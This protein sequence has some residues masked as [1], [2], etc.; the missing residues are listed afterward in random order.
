MT[1]AEWINCDEPGPMLALLKGKISDR[2]AYLFA[3]A[4][5]QLFARLLPDSKQRRGVQLLE[6]I[7]EGTAT[8]QFVSHVAAEVFRAT[9]YS[10]EI[11][12]VNRPDDPYMIARMLHGAIARST[13]VG[14]G[15]RAVACAVMAT[16]FLADEAMTQAAQIVILRD[17]FGNPFRHVSVNRSS[18]PPALIA[19][20]QVIY[21]ERA[22]DRMPELADALKAA[23]C[24]DKDVLRHCRGP[25][26]HVRGCWVVDLILGKR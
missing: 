4:A 14:A 17:I 16:N 12:G 18:L 19:L 10:T 9:P 13:V 23:D 24:D 11:T 26:P 6:Q 7:A 1:E 2:K 22:F 20:G 3:T 8:S 5:F 25:G 21:E 15:A